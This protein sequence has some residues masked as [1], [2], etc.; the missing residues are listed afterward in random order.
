MFVGPFSRKFQ[1]ISLFVPWE[2]SLKYLFDS[3]DIPAEGKYSLD[4]AKGPNMRVMIDLKK[5]SA[6]YGKLSNTIS[7]GYK[8]S[9]RTIRWAGETI[10]AYRASQGGSIGGL[11]REAIGLEDPNLEIGKIE[12]ISD[13]LKARLWPRTPKVIVVNGTI[14]EGFNEKLECPVTIPYSEIPHLPD[15]ASRKGR[16]RKL[17]VG[18]LGGQIV[19]SLD[20]FHLYEGVTPAESVRLIRALLTFHARYFITTN[21]AGGVNPEL[22]VG[23]LVLIRDGINLMGTSPLAGPQVFTD[24]ERCPRVEGAFANDGVRMIAG[25]VARGR[26]DPG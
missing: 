10:Q 16:A 9:G 13:H 6:A 1:F 4:N 5:V 14:S 8:T 12:V 20:R 3:I 26:G 21:S 15:F 11:A 25:I 2:K 7:N 19:A 22:K 23:D 17:V 24:E 18:N